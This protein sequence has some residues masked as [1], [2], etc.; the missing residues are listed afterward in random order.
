[1]PHDVFEQYAADYD[2]WFLEYP[3]VY[4][5][6]LGRISRITGIIPGPS[7]EI[8][9][10]SG[11]FA[12]PLGISLGLE[13]S[14]ALCRI[15]KEQGVA[16]IRGIA[17]QLPFRDDVYQSVLMVTVLCFLDDPALALREIYRVLKPGGFFTLTFLERDGEI[18]RRYT[19][20]S[21]KGRFLSHARYYSREEVFAI[22]G[23][24]GFVPVREDCRKGFCI[25][26]LEKSTR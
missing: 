26:V 18:A 11:R 21:D 10:G 23:A 1:M 25:L 15:A 6:E 2:R 3:T 5:E 19:G 22:A 9:V 17:E 20:S 14:E 7:L 24:A 4:R 12:I 13:P 8:G 16:V